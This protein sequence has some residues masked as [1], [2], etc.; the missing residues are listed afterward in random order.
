MK[1]IIEKINQIKN[2]KYVSIEYCSFPKPRAK[3]KDCTIKKVTKGVYRLGIAYKNLASKKDITTE[4]LPYGEWVQPM[5]NKLIKHNDSYQLRVYMTGNKKHKA[6][7]QWYL[8][9]EPITKQELIDMGAISDS[10]SSHVELFNI[11]LEN[12]IRIGKATK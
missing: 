1:K 6:T 5:V 11:K 10:K 9:D 8:N 12:I 2:G 7:T 4:K 3:F